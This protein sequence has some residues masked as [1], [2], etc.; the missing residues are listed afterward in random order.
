MPPASLTRFSIDSMPVRMPRP[1]S[2]DGPLNAADMP[3]TMS[4]AA[5][6]R[7]GAPAASAHQHGTRDDE[8]GE[9]ALSRR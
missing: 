2:A 5:L 9:G 4:P 6:R 3:S 8:R 7:A 1:S